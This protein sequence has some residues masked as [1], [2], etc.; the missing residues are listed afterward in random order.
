MDNLLT[1]IRLFRIIVRRVE[2]SN[3]E[4]SMSLVKVKNKYQIV[5]PEDVRKKIKIEVGD[6]LEIIEKDGLVIAKPV[7]IVDKSQAYFWTDEWQKGE[8]EAEDAKKKGD[9]KDFDNADKA[10][11]WLKS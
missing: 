10:V 11:K 7:V 6:S 1:F 5:I 9:F 3:K 2:L 4:Q 8:K